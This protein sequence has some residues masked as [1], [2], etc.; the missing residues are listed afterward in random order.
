[1]RL[2][3]PPILL[4]TDRHQARLP[5]EEVA[6]AACAGGCRWLLLRER[7]LPAEE[8]IALGRKLLALAA[9][10]GA[11]LLMS[12]DPEAA[13]LAG[14]AGVHLARDG[15]PAAARAQLGPAALI[16][17]SAH[18]LGEARRAEAAG[19]DYLTLSPVYESASKP[20]YGPALG[21]DGLAAV[22]RAL[23]LP[24]LALG[25]VTAARLAACRAAG[26]AGLAVMGAVM[27][28]EEPEAAMAE[29]VAAWRGASGQAD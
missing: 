14:A 3:E 2:P 21:P 18:D 8:R 4:L 23:A 9:A 26:A 11:T 27:R 25:G 10:C 16:G 24:V 12:G 20:G 17:L 1:M 13:R 22:A 29:L 19:A 28:A 6:R 15:D 7:D 5:L